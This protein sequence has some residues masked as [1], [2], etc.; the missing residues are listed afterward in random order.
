MA[1]ILGFYCQLFLV[2]MDVNLLVGSSRPSLTFGGSALA[3][4]AAGMGYVFELEWGTRSPTVGRSLPQARFYP[5][6][7]FASGLHLVLRCPFKWG[8]PVLGKVWRRVFVFSR[9]RRLLCHSFSSITRKIRSGHL[10]PTSMADAQDLAHVWGRVCSIWGQQHPMASVAG[11][12]GLADTAPSRRPGLSLPDPVPS[13]L[14]ADELFP[15]E[16]PHR[17]SSRDPRVTCCVVSP[18]TGDLIPRRIARIGPPFMV[19]GLGLRDPSACTC[20]YEGVF[21][22][23]PS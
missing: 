20:R 19:T 12:L 5:Q 17:H 11:V 18:L 15:D 14:E 23:C 8:R 13:V 22:I 16:I 1:F 4:V 21:C 3:E 2:A 7:S 10:V 6:S 9:P